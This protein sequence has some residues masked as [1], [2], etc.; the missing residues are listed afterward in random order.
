MQHYEKKDENVLYGMKVIYQATA[1]TT[2]SSKVHFTV[3]KEEILIRR[4][5][6]TCQPFSIMLVIPKLH[7]LPLRL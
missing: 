1:T 3:Q 5:H 6:F 4:Q 7:K 2:Q